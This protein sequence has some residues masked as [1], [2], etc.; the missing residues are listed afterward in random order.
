MCIRVGGGNCESSSIFFWILLAFDV[1]GNEQG[2]KEI[3]KFMTLIW[4]IFS[5]V[6]RN[7]K[8]NRMQIW[9]VCMSDCHIMSHQ[10]KLHLTR[11][12]TVKA[13]YKLYHHYTYQF[14]QIAFFCR[15]HLVFGRSELF[16][17]SSSFLMLLFLVS[18][19]ACWFVA[20]KME[21]KLNF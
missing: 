2:T 1:N 17:F 8:K 3:V 6:L 21:R 18:P 15:L 20:F 13:I 5:C 7:E 12:R 16:F 4:N 9:G 19:R 14:C 10:L 11:T